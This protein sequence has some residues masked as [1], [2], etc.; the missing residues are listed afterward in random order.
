MPR[1][2]DLLCIYASCGV[3]IDPLAFTICHLILRA[4]QLHR[5]TRSIAIVYT[6]RRGPD[7]TYNRRRQVR[8]I[9][10]TKIIK[11]K[12]SID[13]RHVAHDHSRQRRQ[14]HRQAYVHQASC[15]KK[16]LEWRRQ[17]A[18]NVGRIASITTPR[19]LARGIS[20]RPLS[21]FEQW[22][23][24]LRCHRRRCCGLPGSR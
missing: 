19:P 11:G 15:I 7:Q 16:S 6:T 22:A 1:K 17:P 21:S 4:T 2:I 14:C 18:S 8:C 9:K 3:S 10:A 5:D 12:L 24:Y 23:K 13:V 20:K